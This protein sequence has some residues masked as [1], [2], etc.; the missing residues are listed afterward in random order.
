MVL[1][2]EV[3]DVVDDEV[4]SAPI[5]Q[6]FEGNLCFSSNFQASYMNYLIQFLA[7]ID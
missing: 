2:N 5:P 1:E 3:V 6:I 7:W 4:G